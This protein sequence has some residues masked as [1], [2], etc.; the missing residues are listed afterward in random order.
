MDREI[1]GYA[2]LDDNESQMLPYE[3][4]LDI[5]KL[6]AFKNYGIQNNYL[7]LLDE[8]G[9]LYRGLLRSF[10]TTIAKKVSFHWQTVYRNADNKKTHYFLWKA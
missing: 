3:V 1:A 9:R 6:I 8:D 10:R 5:L 4:E 7:F 2:R